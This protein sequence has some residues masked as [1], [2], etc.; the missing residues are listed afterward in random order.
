VALGRQMEAMKLEPAQRVIE[1]L[2]CPP[3]RKDR[4]FSDA[5]QCWL[6]MRVTQ[7]AISGALRLAKKRRS[8][9]AEVTWALRSAFNRHLDLPAAGLSRAIVVKTLDSKARK[10][11]ASARGNIRANLFQ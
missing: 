4:L 2:T 10:G 1:G 11:T 3:G 5:D 7:N 9:A 8:Y 6:Y